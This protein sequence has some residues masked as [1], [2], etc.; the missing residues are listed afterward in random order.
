[1]L[2]ER[3]GEPG[4]PALF[5]SLVGGPFGPA[6]VQ[7]CNVG[8]PPDSG[9]EPGK[10]LRT[11]LGGRGSYGASGRSALGVSVVGSW[12][13]CGTG[14]GCALRGGFPA[15]SRRGSRLSEKARRKSRGGGPR[16]LGLEIARSHSARFSVAGRSGTVVGYFATHL[17]ALIWELSFAK[18]LPAYFFSKMRPKS[19]L[20]PRGN[21]TSLSYIG[22]SKT[23]REGKRAAINPRSRS[24][25]LAFFPP[26]FQRKPAS[27][28]EPG[29]ATGRR[30]KA[31]SR[32]SP[33]VRSTGLPL[34]GGPGLDRRR[35][36]PATARSRAGD[37]GFL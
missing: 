3:R 5:R 29:G 25:A 7:T 22:R 1:M 24:G 36:R 26:A 30:P 37:P 15:R 20:E 28:P 4:G 6:Q 33:E 31:V 17:R 8:F 32:H 27:T 18:M 21:R 9:R 10:V 13:H 12:S 11:P 35:S 34:V 2:P 19:I 23:Q 14:A 16:P